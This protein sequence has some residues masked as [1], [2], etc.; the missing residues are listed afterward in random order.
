[1]I[2]ARLPHRIYRI[3]QHNLIGQ[4]NAAL[5]QGAI[6]VKK[7]PPAYVAPVAGA[8]PVGSLPYIPASES[9]DWRLAIRW[10][11]EESKT[12]KRRTLR[13]LAIL[14]EYNA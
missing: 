5:A 13:R 4:V 7:C 6:V 1:M 10:P 11:Y 3:R 2:N 8:D 9:I 14:R 12:R